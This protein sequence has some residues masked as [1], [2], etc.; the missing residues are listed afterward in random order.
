MWDVLATSFL[1]IPEAF[2]VER[3]EI[4]IEKSGP[5]AGRTFRKNNTGNFANIVTNVDREKF[6]QYFMESFSK[7]L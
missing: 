5:G 1:N 4:D 6:Y 2:T 7:D 3:A